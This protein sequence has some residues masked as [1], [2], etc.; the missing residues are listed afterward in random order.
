MHCRMRHTGKA[1]Y[2]V[3]STDMSASNPA[4]LGPQLSA[5]CSVVDLPFLECWRALRAA[6]R[7]TF[8]KQAGMPNVLIEVRRQYTEHEECA[9]MEAVHGAV[10]EAFKIPTGDRNVRLIVHQPHRFAC[11]SWSEKPEFYTLISIDAFVGR[12]LDA[13]RSLY[14]AIV[15]NLGVFGIPRDHVEILLHEI[16]KENWGLRGGEAGCDVELGFKVDV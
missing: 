13:K 6:R 8:W 9:L 14:K 3:L 7:R 4:L 15:R 5:A 12:S 11:P 2:E 10:H 16:P 1:P